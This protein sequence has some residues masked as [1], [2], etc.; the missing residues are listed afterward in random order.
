MIMVAIDNTFYADIK[1]QK[2]HNIGKKKKSKHITDLHQ[3]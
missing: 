1:V 2:L 3:Q